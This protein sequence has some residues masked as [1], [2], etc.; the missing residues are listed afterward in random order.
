MR[1]ALQYVYWEVSPTRFNRAYL[2][3]RVH[4]I[5]QYFAVF[6]SYIA[7]TG[8]QSRAF[9]CGVVHLHLPDPDISIFE[10]LMLQY[11]Q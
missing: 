4:R 3:V 2:Q 9:G 11:I 10:V 8:L 6:R 7:L 1:N 5:N